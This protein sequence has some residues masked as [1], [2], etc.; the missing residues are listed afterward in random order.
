MHL[1][2]NICNSNQ[3]C[4]HCID[5]EINLYV[6]SYCGLGW[7]LKQV[8]ESGLGGGFWQ[9]YGLNPGPHRDSELK[10]LG[11]QMDCGRQ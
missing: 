11:V 3:T 7:V 4:N 5:G 1:H 9:K 2:F 8:W 6:L 10:R